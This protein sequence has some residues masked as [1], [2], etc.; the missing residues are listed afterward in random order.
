MF[1]KI[2]Y[3]PWTNYRYGIWFVKNN[4]FMNGSNHIPIWGPRYSGIESDVDKMPLHVVCAKQWSRCVEISVQQ[5][6][7][8]PAERSI[9]VL[10]ED[11]MTNEDEWSRIC[12][13][14]GI[15]SKP[16]IQLWKDTVQSGNDEKWRKNLKA[17][18]ISE[19]EEVFNKLPLN[20][21]SFFNKK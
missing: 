1:D 6:S 2:R 5:L 16:V 20:L 17:N 18:K 12:D 9:T 3:F 15:D 4:F 14:I 19:M 8:L 7:K 21:H 11:L 10:Y 13:F